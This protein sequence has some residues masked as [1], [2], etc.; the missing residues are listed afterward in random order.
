MTET[1]RYMARCR[2]CRRKGAIDAEMYTITLQGRTYTW[3]GIP[4][5]DEDHNDYTRARAAEASVVRAA[6]GATYPA[7]VRMPQPPAWN[8]FQLDMDGIARSVLIRV[9]LWCPDCNDQM[10]VTPL[11]A[12]RNDAKRCNDVCMRATS[13]TCD[14][15]CG[16]QNHGKA[17]LVGSVRV[18]A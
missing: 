11:K 2:T 18:G 7:H 13:I 14:C 3:P 4:I 10:R 17:W 5:L 16:G 8:R 1:V 6:A 15:S 9:G 12:T